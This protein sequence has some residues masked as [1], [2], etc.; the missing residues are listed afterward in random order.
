M[1][2]STRRVALI[3]KFYDRLYQVHHEDCLHAGG[4]KTFAKICLASTST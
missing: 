4:K 1:M 3:E 2:K